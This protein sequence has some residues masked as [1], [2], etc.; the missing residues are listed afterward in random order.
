[1]DEECDVGIFGGHR[2]MKEWSG[3]VDI[4]RFWRRAEWSGS[5]VS[6]WEVFV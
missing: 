6:G 4:F 5:A 3:L 1:M 2:W